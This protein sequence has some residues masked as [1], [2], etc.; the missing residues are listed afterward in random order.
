M[1]E[2]DFNLAIETSSRAG[3]VAIGRSGRLLEAASLPPQRRHAV[4]LMPMIDRLTARHGARPA[5]LRE[6]YC[7]VGPGSFTGLRIGVT[8]AKVIAQVTGARIAPV[9]SLD[10]VARNAPAGVDRLAVC[11]NAKR[12]QCFTGVY[13][14]DGEDWRPLL[15]PSLLG[16][17]EL[18]RRIEPPLAV[19][20]DALPPF[21]WPRG[22]T[23]LPPELAEPRAE[24]VWRL[25]RRAADAGRFVTPWALTP[26]Y[27]RLPEA[28]E[29]WQLKHSPSV[30]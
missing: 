11:L 13:Q 16:P 10:V 19:I 14:R 29:V 3:S 15:E 1:I 5:D 9:G 21:D 4:D 23:L 25:G 8:T 30:S 20:G 2:G 18:M 24:I 6:L 26:L 22:V 28:E 27:V 12:G 17:A 7:S